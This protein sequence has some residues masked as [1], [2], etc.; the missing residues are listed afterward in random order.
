MTFATRR[1]RPVVASKLIC[2]GDGPETSRRACAFP[3]LH[4]PTRVDLS[5]AKHLV[6]SNE[7]NLVKQV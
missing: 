2:S 3:S 5:R 1:G 6:A 7:N 4:L